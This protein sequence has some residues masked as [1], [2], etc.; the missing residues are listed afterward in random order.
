VATVGLVAM[1][2]IETRAPLSPSVAASRS[3]RSGIAVISLVLSATAYCRRMAEN[4]T[5]GG[6]ERRDKVE[7][8]RAG[9]AVVASSSHYA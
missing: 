2:S 6:G 9:G 7:R 8:R 1:A 3:S 5:A 4:E